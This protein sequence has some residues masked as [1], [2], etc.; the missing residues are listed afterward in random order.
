MSMVTDCFACG[1]ALHIPDE[2]LGRDVKCPACHHT[3]TASDSLFNAPQVSQATPPAAAKLYGGPESYG[4]PPP[5]YGEQ[6][7]TREFFHEA[8]EWSGSGEKP[9]KVQAIAV[10]MMIGGII[11]LL[12]GTIEVF[13]CFMLAWPGTYYN[14]ALG[15]MA[16]VRA[17]ALMG[18]GARD[19]LPPRN[20]AVMQ[21]INV[22]NLDFFNLTFGIITLVFLDAPEVK[23]YFRR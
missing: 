2:L 14:L 1:R 18:T 5:A 12:L 6:P 15:I 22:V 11:A 4:V 7:S 17:A 16:I 13:T 20:I 10:M 23:A 3:F 8:P 21:I 19:E 9:Q